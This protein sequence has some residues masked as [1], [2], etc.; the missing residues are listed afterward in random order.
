MKRRLLVAGAALVALVASTAAGPADADVSEGTVDFRAGLTRIDGFGF[1][2]AFQRGNWMQELTPENQKE[3]LDLLLSRSKGA[4]FSILRLGI[5][6]SLDYSGDKM[7]SIAP[8]DP[9]GPD[10]PPVYEWD[11][12]DGGQVWLA[13]H[14]KRYGVQRFYADAWSAPGYMKDN[15][16]DING[17]TLCGLAGTSCAS[18]DWRQAYANYLVQFARFYAQEG[19]RITDLGFTNEPDLTVSYASMRFTPEQAAE[20]SK[21]VGPTL[22][23]SG[24]GTRLACCDAAGWDRQAA[25]TAAIEADPVAR[26]WVKTHT[27]HSYV[28]PSD[29]PLPTSR[30]TWMSEWQ[31]NGTTWNEAWD[32][33]SGYDGFRVAEHIHQVMVDANA[34]AYIVWLGASR[35]FTRAPIQL[36]GENYHV[37]KR[38]W[39][40]A[41]Y[42][43][44][45]RPG[46][47][48]VAVDV[49]DP[50][51]KVSAYR[52]A[53]GREVIV[54]LNTA[55][56][57]VPA[58]LKLKG[59]GGRV[60][61]YLTDETHAVERTDSARLRGGR[62]T[63][64]LPPRSLTTIVLR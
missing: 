46:A 60:S 38:L 39:A 27:G 3:V 29:V 24:L 9:G 19:I 56:T 43:R 31:P 6:S 1:S 22:A 45:I 11:G 23:R 30:H 15:G 32:D 2:E 12:L 61:T 58:S 55:T 51:L 34:N 28:D 33:G 41:S 14:A 20:F 21:I 36:D 25:Y 37:A 17:G 59:A 35:S 13:K 5:G 54:L 64:E 10:A 26:R 63:A 42:S 18:G 50:A 49:A 4:G 44:F 57:A 48:R 53:D 47:V 52:N 7:K 40:F 16:T 62:L 8:T